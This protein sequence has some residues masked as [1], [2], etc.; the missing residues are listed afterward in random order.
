MSPEAA[1]RLLGVALHE[2]GYQG[3]FGLMVLK[4]QACVS[5]WT[6][7]VCA[8]TPPVA[9]GRSL[10]PADVPRVWCDWPVEVHEVGQPTA[11]AKDIPSIPCIWSVP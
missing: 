9:G 8:Y 6:I 3:S 5:G 2:Q 4:A 1:A 11:Q 7:R 10:H